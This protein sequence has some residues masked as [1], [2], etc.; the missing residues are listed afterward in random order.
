MRTYTVKPHQIQIYNEIKK[1][2]EKNLTYYVFQQ[3]LI[4]PNLTL[5]ELKKFIKRSVKRYCYDFSKYDYKPQFENQIIK[6]YCFFETSKD[7]FW[8]QHENIIVEE[9]INN[10]GLHFH[11]FV[12]S[13]RFFFC[14]HSYSFYLFE[15]LNSQRNKLKSF[16]KYDYNRINK[17]DEDFILYHTK[18]MMFRY[19][20]ELVMK[21]Y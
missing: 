11:L 18:Q 1:L 8:S 12:S 19:S 3:S 7:F 6:Y 14:P 13:D 17:L 10:I 2:P 16:S 20:P 5:N 15:E 9:D 4:Y 21:N